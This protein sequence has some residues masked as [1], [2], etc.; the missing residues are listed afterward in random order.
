MIVSH[1]VNREGDAMQW[2]ESEEAAAQGSGVRRRSRQ[3]EFRLGSNSR[4]GCV[5]EVYVPVWDQLQTDAGSE[6]GML[7]QQGLHWCHEHAQLL[8]RILEAGPIA[9]RNIENWTA[10]VAVAKRQVDE[11]ARRDEEFKREQLRVGGLEESVRHI[12]V[13]TERIIGE[14]NQARDHLQQRHDEEKR[15]ERG[16]L[17]RGFAVELDEERMKLR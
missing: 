15:T 8:L 17:K 12:E 2:L 3:C 5:P 11:R 4:C 16:R 10:A 13:T 14:M 6:S 7:A 1:I 9:Y